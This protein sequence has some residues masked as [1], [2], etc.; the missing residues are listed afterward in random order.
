MGVDV[1]VGECM[2]VDVCVWVGECMHV[3]VCVCEW[4]WMCG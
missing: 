4:V 2:H 1:W 3:D